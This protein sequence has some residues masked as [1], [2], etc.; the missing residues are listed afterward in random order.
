MEKGVNFLTN[1]QYLLDKTFVGIY[2]HATHNKLGK[3]GRLPPK[4]QSSGE[5]K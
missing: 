3:A 4:D 2:G 5:P 1:P